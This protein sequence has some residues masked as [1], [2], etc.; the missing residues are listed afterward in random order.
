MWANHHNICRL[1]QRS[2][3]TFAVLNLLLLFWTVFLPFPTAVLSRYLPVGEFRTAA[4]VFYGATLTCTAICYNVLWRY[5]AT[6][7]RLL[8]PEADATIVRAISREFLI[9][10]FLYAA[11]TLVAFVSVVLS[12]TIHGA[13]A[14]LYVIPNRTRP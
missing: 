2:N 10:P 14:L 3:H 7:H 12:L 4:A 13:L 6:D 1:I 9:G 5:A 11:A 8:R